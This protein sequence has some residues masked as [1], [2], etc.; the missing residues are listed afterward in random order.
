MT[1][2]ETKLGELKKILNRHN[3]N[4]PKSALWSTDTPK[5]ELR[6]FFWRTDRQNLDI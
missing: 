6:F 4:G 1:K 3:Q 5:V 2:D